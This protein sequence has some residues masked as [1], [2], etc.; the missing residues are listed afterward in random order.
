[1]FTANNNLYNLL[2]NG[3]HEVRSTSPMGFTVTVR[4]ISI[5][6]N[7]NHETDNRQVLKPVSNVI[8]S[9]TTR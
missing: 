6:E 1:M 8:D 7:A 9:N 3:P 2:Y 4:N 5:Y